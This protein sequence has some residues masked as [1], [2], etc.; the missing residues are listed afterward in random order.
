MNLLAW[1]HRQST[2]AIYAGTLLLTALLGWIDYRTGFEITFAVFYY[3]PVAGSTYFVGPRAG[4]SVAG[5]SAAAWLLADLLSGHTYSSTMVGVWNTSA[6]LLS[7]LVLA[8]LLDALRRAYEHEQQLARRD[9]LTGAYNR[10]HFF[11]LLEL[12]MV[13]ARRFQ[14]A[15]TLVLFDLDGFKAINDKFGHHEGDAVLRAVVHAAGRAL[16]DSDLLARLGGDEFVVL[17]PETAA[18]PGRH[19]VAKLQ[20]G[21]TQE[22]QKHE[23]PVTFSLGVLTCLD[24]PATPDELV[25]MVDDLTYAAK[26]EGKS[27]A[28]FEVLVARRT[29]PT[30]APR[31]ESRGPPSRA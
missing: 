31:E 25:R 19:V 11:E 27:T 5:A 23:W 6:R 26:R 17:L 12:E 7:F 8:G 13:R 29:G 2:A 28:V 18:E 3:L 4:A 15:L 21:M 24:P 9:P 20:A 22:M 16:R 10:R 1:F 14:R 30:S